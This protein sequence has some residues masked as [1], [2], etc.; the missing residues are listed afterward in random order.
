MNL[1]LNSVSSQP[2]GSYQTPASSSRSSKA[3]GRLASLAASGIVM[4]MLSSGALAAGSVAAGKAVF[5]RVNCASCHGVDAKTS[6]DPSYPQLAGQHPDYL[7]HALKAYQRGQANAA[8]SA[9]ARK[10]AIMGAFAV[11]LSDKDIEDVAAYL[12]SLPGNLAV[13]R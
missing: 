7:R 13:R 1:H 11:Q 4:A 3:L 2:S 10:N 12:S 6:I 9:N 8:P 5:E